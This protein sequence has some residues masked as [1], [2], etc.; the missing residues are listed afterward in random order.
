MFLE[1]LDVCKHP[2]SSHL[3]TLDDSRTPNFSR[4]SSVGYAHSKLAKAQPSG[5][6]REEQ[7]LE[8]VAVMILIMIVG[9]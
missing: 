2:S 5:D 9:C 3:Y 8:K 4:P 7:T 1:C 6:R